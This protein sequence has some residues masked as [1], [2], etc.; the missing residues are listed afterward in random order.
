MARQ[1]T[2]SIRLDGDDLRLIE[3]AA[4]REEMPASAWARRELRRASTMRAR[5]EALADAA[6]DWKAL[7]AER[8]LVASKIKELLT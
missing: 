1:F 6:L 5:V 4:L 3:S 7:G 2:F 8:H